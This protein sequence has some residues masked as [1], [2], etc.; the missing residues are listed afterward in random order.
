MIFALVAAAA[1]A[2]YV[3]YEKVVMA[4]PAKGSHGGPCE[5]K[6]VPLSKW[7]RFVDP[8]IDC[9]S[10]FWIIDQM[11]SV[12]D[13]WPNWLHTAWTYQN[14]APKN[15]ADMA[16]IANVIRVQ[17]GLERLP[18]PM[19]LADLRRAQ[20]EEREHGPGRHMMI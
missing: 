13:P 1:V 19:T 16:E 14:I 3:Y 2:S 6:E 7:D 8:T 9:H 12:L 18:W 5:K 17:N 20:A 15:A 10:R 4:P 11:D